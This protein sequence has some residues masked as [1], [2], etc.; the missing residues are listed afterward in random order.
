MTTAPTCPT[1]FNQLRGTGPN[2]FGLAQQI[3]AI[4]RATDLKSAITALNLM[5][6]II[7]QITN[8]P[9]LINNIGVQPEYPP[10]S[11]FNITSD[12]GEH[13][14][15]MAQSVIRNPEDL[16]QYV[17]LKTVAS[18]AWMDDYGHS[19]NYTVD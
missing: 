3:A 4:P 7:Q 5:E 17:E 1:G 8:F 2:L 15:D 16:E 11:S 14:R 13:S 10:D 6:T 12:W 18:V 19:L 9:P